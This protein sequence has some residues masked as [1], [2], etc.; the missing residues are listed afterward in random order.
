MASDETAF[1]EG[2]ADLLSAAGRGDGRA[3]DALERAAARIRAGAPPVSCRV[4]PFVR[5]RRPTDEAASPGLGSSDQVAMLLGNAEPRGTNRAYVLYT[6]PAGL[7]ALSIDVTL[8]LAGPDGAGTPVPVSDWSRRIV[9][10]TVF[11]L[12]PDGRP[13][14]RPA[15]DD[16][17]TLALAIEPDVDLPGPDRFGFDQRFLQKLVVRLRISDD[18]VPLAAAHTTLDICSAGQL[19]SLY[20]RILERLLAQDAARQAERAGHPDPGLTYHPWFPVLWIG[21]EKLALYKSALVSDIVHKEHHLTNPAWLLRVGIYLELLTCLGIIEA[22]RNEVG[23]LLDPHERDVFDNGSHYAAIRERIDGPAWRSVWSLNQIAFPSHGIPRAGPVSALNLLRK[24][25]ATLRFL[26]VHHE[27]LNVAIELAGAN[28]EN[29]Q[30]T[31]QRVF[32]DAERAVL[33]KT[34]EA[35]PELGFLPTQA[36]EFVLWHRKG[37]LEVGRQ[38]RI[39]TRIGRLM[40]DQDGLFHSASRQYRASM[41]VVAETAKSQGLMD[42]TG[43]VCVPPTVSLVAAVD[44]RDAAAVELLQRADGYG[45][46]PEVTAARPATAPPLEDAVELLEQVPMLRVLSPEQVLELAKTSRALTL[47]PTQ[48]FVIQGQPGTSMFV[49]ADG[50]VEV[51]VRQADGH[52]IVVDTMGRGEV[53]GEMSLLTGEVRSATVRAADGALVY[54][55]GRRQFEPLLQANPQW[56]DELEEIMGGRLNDRDAYLASLPGHTPLRERLRRAWI[57]DPPRDARD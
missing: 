32:R 23:D 4:V 6:L 10:P 9:E 31:W 43:D 50:E 54:E 42:H 56:I 41:N 57:G 19:G 14:L 8:A 18:G 55:V 11:E 51:V 30:E 2:L 52:D 36:R 44:R 49:V 29:A 27:D 46:P 48:R 38:L 3:A 33:R 35:F 1:L 21:Q 28:L 24:K 16:D 47:A 5:G 22:V 25:Q 13:R 37:R 7:G 26:E 40:A 20:Q 39:P 45:G 15:R 12:D 34:A 17:C 53:V